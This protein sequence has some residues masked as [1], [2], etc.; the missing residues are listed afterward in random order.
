MLGQYFIN[1]GF[2]FVVLAL[3]KEIGSLCG[4]CSDVVTLALFG[5][6]DDVGV[7]IRTCRV[8]VRVLLSRSEPQGECTRSPMHTCLVFNVDTCGLVHARY[9]CY[10]MRMAC[11]SAAHV[12]GGW[13]ITSSPSCWNMVWLHL[14][15]CLAV[16]FGPIFVAN[17]LIPW[18]YPFAAV[19]LFRR[20]PEALLVEVAWQPTA[21]LHVCV[22]EAWLLCVS[23]SCAFAL[24]VLWWEGECP[25]PLC[26]AFRDG[27]PSTNVP[28]P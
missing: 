2:R 9:S 15:R 5:A 10:W 1:F 24:C 22:I 25:A 13:H 7:L 21:F 6:L 23:A 14:L 8:L 17:V 16:A 27:D 28:K 12:L 18:F 20:G 11:D 4:Y 26:I 3:R 19:G